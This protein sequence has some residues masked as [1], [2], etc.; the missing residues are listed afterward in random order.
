MIPVIASFYI[1]CRFER[2]SCCYQKLDGNFIQGKPE[3]VVKD[4]DDDFGLTI[5]YHGVIGGIY[6]EINLPEKFV[7]F[8]SDKYTF[9]FFEANQD[10][11]L[12][13]SRHLIL[14]SL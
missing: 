3:C 5:G 8:G 1:V 10:F 2:E 11:T 12:V 14:T 9:P 13:G 6:F 4:L 7:R